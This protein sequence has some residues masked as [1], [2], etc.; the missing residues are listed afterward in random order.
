MSVKTEHKQNKMSTTTENSKT[1][2]LLIKPKKL[3]IIKKKEPEP[4]SEE[5]TV[6]VIRF[7]RAVYGDTDDCDIIGME[8]VEEMEFDTIEEAR[9]EFNDFEL[10]AVGELLY[11]DMISGEDEDQE[12]IEC[13]GTL[14]QDY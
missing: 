12:N 6:Y 9:T 5:K 1:K 8:T 3:R 11:L 10:E 4:E 7:E 2:K 14:G 13:R